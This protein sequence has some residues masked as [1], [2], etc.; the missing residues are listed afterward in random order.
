MVLA[1][2]CICFLGLLLSC[3]CTG[4][5]SDPSLK[6]AAAGSLTIVFGEVS[7]AF[8]EETGIPVTVSYASTGHLAQ[9]IRNGGPFDLFAA[10][11]ARHIDML[12]DEG[13][14]DGN[15]RTVY[16]LGELV[17]I[18]QPNFEAEIHAIEDLTT[19]NLN[20]IA[21]ANPEHAPY[22]LAAKQAMESAGVWTR[23][24]DRL[25][26]GETVR[27]AEQLVETGNAQA[28]LVAASTVQGT[29]LVVREIPTNLYDAIEH[30]L[31]VLRSAHHR[32]EALRFVEFLKS[33]EG[34]RLLEAYRLRPPDA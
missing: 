32:Q 25:V 21:I 8:R 29:A 23:I 26:Y 19:N 27:Q 33:G 5:R 9:Q 1:R 13:F 16:A 20:H 7:E 6:I 11:D 34:R 14:L 22:G 10:A 18:T 4:A 24:A 30:T 17:L 12:I 28:G 15:T 31:A 3:A 2:R